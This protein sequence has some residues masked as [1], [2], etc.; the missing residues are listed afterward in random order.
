MSLLGTDEHCFL[1]AGWFRSYLMLMIQVKNKVV[2]MYLP[3]TSQI[4]SAN[5]SLDVYV[6]CDK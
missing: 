3:M 5:K 1:M 6:K 4:I 2:S